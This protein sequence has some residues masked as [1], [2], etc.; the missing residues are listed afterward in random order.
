M[1]KSV[2]FLL[3]I[4]LVIF[5]AV[6]CDKKSTTEPGQTNGTPATPQNDFIVEVEY[7]TEQVTM[8]LFSGGNANSIWQTITEYE[9]NFECKAG[10]T[11]NSIT[12]D[13]LDRDEVTVTWEKH[14][15]V[16]DC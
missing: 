2:L 5:I 1:R 11:N 6:S 12:I 13:V 10:E 8:V 9:Q 3:V 7:K 14:D 16:F 15:I 4:S